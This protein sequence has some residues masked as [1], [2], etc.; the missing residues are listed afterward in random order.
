[1]PG[2][3]LSQAQFQRP[4]HQIEAK[5][6][7]HF[8][9]AKRELLNARLGKRMQATGIQD[10]REYLRKAEENGEFERLLD[11][12]TTNQ[13]YFW[14]EPEHFLH[15]SRWIGEQKGQSAAPLRIWCAASS[16]GEEAYTLAMTALE[17]LNGEREVKILASDLSERMLDKA[18]LGVYDA[19]RVQGLPAGWRDRYFVRLPDGR[20]Q[21]GALLRSTVRFARLNL[22]ELPAAPM[23]LDAIFCRNVMIY[24]DRPVQQHLVLELQG[25]L[26]PGGWLYTGMA[27]S[28]LAIHHGLIN[29]APSAYQRPA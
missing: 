15:L 20:W 19:G 3:Q 13:T 26:R 22:L 14:R 6:G 1:M 17:A 2:A 28:L 4:A 25:R 5:A 23:R 7:L 8:S 24:F 16:S 11:Q 10:T 12:V 29:R 27:E 9:A 18:V 21:A